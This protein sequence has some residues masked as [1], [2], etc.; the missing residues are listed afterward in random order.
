M[1]L[2][3]DELNSVVRI[4]DKQSSSLQDQPYLWRKI[5]NKYSLIFEKPF[6]VPLFDNEAI[7]IQQGLKTL[8]KSFEKLISLDPNEWHSIQPVWSHEY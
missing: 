1:S 6:Y 3:F 4:F 2:N 8:S 7:S 5:D